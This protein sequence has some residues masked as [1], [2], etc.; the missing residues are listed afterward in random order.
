MLG[1]P[2]G[3]L[4]DID[5]PSSIALAFQV[6]WSMIFLLFLTAWFMGR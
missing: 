1:Q 2:A 5:V 4:R 6:I 3:F